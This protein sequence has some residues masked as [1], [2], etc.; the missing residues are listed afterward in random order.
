MKKTYH[1]VF[2]GLSAPE[3]TFRERMEALGVEPET[4]TRILGH[5]PVIMKQGLTLG[6]ARLYAEAV[7]EAGGKVTIQEYGWIH[8]S[9]WPAARSNIPSL[10]EFTMCPQCGMKQLRKALCER[11]GCPLGPGP[12]KQQADQSGVK[13]D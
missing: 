3:E 1:I 8:E 4:V 5:A 11:C 2:Q 10:D 6:P 12:D 9:E 13:Q 7:Q